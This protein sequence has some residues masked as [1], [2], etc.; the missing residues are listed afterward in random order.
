MLYRGYADAKGS[1]GISGQENRGGNGLLRPA[2]QIERPGRGSAARFALLH[3]ATRVLES[4]GGRGRGKKLG[5]R[6]SAVPVPQR[7]QGNAGASR[8]AARPEHEVLGKS[9]YRESD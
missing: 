5:G 7:R 4:R 8:R 2:E 3:R 6:S 9:S 1:R